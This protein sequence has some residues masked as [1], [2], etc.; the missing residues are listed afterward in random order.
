M[1][2]RP[3]TPYPNPPPCTPTA[4]SPDSASIEFDEYSNQYE[5]VFRDM[6]TLV[7]KITTMKI[8]CCN[9]Y[10]EYCLSDTD[11]LNI[12]KWDKLSLALNAAALEE[13]RIDVLQ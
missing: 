1:S 4:L 6:R 11:W 2:V 5:K 3:Y 13:M 10:E 12:L 9:D 7:R 8:D